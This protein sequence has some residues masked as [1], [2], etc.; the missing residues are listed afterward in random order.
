M[1]NIAE[2]LLSISKSLKKDEFDNARKSFKCLMG[3]VVN[4]Q[5]EDSEFVIDKNILK[6]RTL[7]VKKVRISMFLNIIQEKMKE[8]I[9]LS[10]FIL[11]L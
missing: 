11:R 8:N 6:I 3:D 7:G 4:L 5:L 9:I 2:N 10:N 1:L